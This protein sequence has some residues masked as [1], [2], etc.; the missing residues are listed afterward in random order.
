[1]CQIC[2]TAKDLSVDEALKFIGWKSVDGV[3]PPCVDRL[4]GELIGE[5]APEADRR[6]ERDWTKANER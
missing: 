3:L 5:P 4:I 6:M 2:D 1:M